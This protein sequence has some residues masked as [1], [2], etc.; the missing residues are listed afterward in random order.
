MKIGLNATCL[1]ERPSGAKQRFIGIY[2][3]L[4]K[5]MP[6]A[7]FTVYQAKDCDLSKCFP[8]S[9]NVMFITTP[10]P[11]YG[12]IRKFLAGLGYWRN[13]FKLRQFDLFE[14][15]HLPFTKSPTGKNMLTM[16]DIRGVSQY[17]GL[18]ERLEFGSVLVNAFRKADHVITVSEAMRSEILAFSPDLQV[19]VI[20]NGID[21]TEFAEVDADM[22]DKIPV[23][24]G[25]SDGFLLTVGHFEKRKNYARLIEALAELHKR[26][27]RLKLVMVGNESGEMHVIQALIVRAGL[28]DYVA[29]LNG[30]SDSELRGLYRMAGLFVFPSFYEGFGIPVLEAMASGCPMVLSDIPVFREITQNQGVYFAYDKV[31]ELVSAIETVL[32]SDAERRR[33]V[34]YG[35]KRAKDF[36]FDAVAA[37]MEALYRRLL[38]TTRS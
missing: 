31:H 37:D 14:G 9:A 18:A 4:F 23:K 29:I 21:A 1:S 34:S 5:R 7:D 32:Y 8:P 6:Y 20:Y 15:Y 13:A 11:S 25:L 36:S 28:S 2:A 26:G 38:D 17:S 3:G 22:L 19:S 33:L 12:R 24:F 10:I 30:V 27:H 35:V 16:H